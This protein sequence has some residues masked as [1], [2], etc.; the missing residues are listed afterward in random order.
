MKRT[1]K[2]SSP[3]SFPRANSCNEIGPINF[4]IKIDTDDSRQ[5]GLSFC[6]KHKRLSCNVRMWTVRATHDFKMCVRDM[7]DNPV[8]QVRY[9]YGSH[10]TLTINKLSQMSYGASHVLH[11]SAPS[12]VIMNSYVI[13]CCDHHL[14][15][16]WNVTHTCN[17]HTRSVVRLALVNHLFD[18]I[19]VNKWFVYHGIL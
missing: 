16:K 4:D 18:A 3:S 1:K 17:M 12:T 11:T 9:T 2:V 8:W 6:T 7:H 10:S 14:F 13:C 15:Y 19:T 5:G